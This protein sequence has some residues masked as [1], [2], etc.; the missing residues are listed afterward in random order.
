MTETMPPEADPA[1][2]AAW[3]AASLAHL[4]RIEQQWAEVYRPLWEAGYDAGRAEAVR[5]RLAV[6]AFLDGQ[7]ARCATEGERGRCHAHNAPW[8]CRVKRLMGALGG[9]EG[10]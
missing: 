1:R 7:P 10:G 3:R 4:S 5:L 8:P 2:E 9:E 6:A